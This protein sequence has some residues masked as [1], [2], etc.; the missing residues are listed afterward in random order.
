M[1]NPRRGNAASGGQRPV[2]APA[3]RSR[4]QSGIRVGGIEPLR[5]LR[6]LEVL[7]GLIE[8]IGQP[9][10]AAGPTAAALL[11]FD[12]YTLRAPFHVAVPN[13]RSVHRS[14]HVVHRGRS[15]ERLDT[16]IALGVPCLSATRLLIELAAT[17]G[18]R[19]LTA[20]LDSALRDGLTSEDFLHR[21]LVALRSRGRTGINRLLAVLAGSELSRG[22]HSYLERAFL[23]LLDEL[24]FPRPLTQQVLA[25]RQRKLVRVDCRFPGTNVVVELLGYQW[26]RTPMQLHEDAERVNRLQ[27]DGFVVMQ[28]TY[29]HVV[30]RSPVMRGNLTEALGPPAA[31]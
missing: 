7:H 4:D 20:A 17:E 5:F 6:N 1:T 10:W 23:E 8:S 29:T 12:G 15:I 16:T 2:T 11:G 9:C 25:K 19:R 31:A 3:L 26:H 24:G 14:P 28:F 27:L 30:T 22:G 18:P 13:G 21:R